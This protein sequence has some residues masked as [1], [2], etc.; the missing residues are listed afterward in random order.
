MMQSSK[1]QRKC[2]MNIQ[3]IMVRKQEEQRLSPRMAR[4]SL[5]RQKNKRPKKSMVR[6]RGET[7]D[8]SDLKLPRSFFAE[9]A[10]GSLV[11]ATCSVFA[12][13]SDVPAV[14]F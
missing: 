6:K 12:V 4:A 3:Q 5:Q 9:V 8:S 14:W 1:A 7:M 13:A 10:D 11:D 2:D